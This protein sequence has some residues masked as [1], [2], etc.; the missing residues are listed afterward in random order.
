MRSV[1]RLR[2]A[3]PRALRSRRFT[4][5]TLA[6]PRP[7]C[8]TRGGVPRK[9]LRRH[10]AQRPRP[11]GIGIGITGEELR[12]AEPRGQPEHLATN[13]AEAHRAQIDSS[14]YPCTLEMHR[15]LAQMYVAD[16]R[17]TATYEAMAPGMAQ[18]VHDAI[19]ANAARRAPG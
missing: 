7:L 4:R 8:R 17:F 3:G 5:A 16:P 6:G 10:L 19:E 11:G 15:A 12:K 14:F 18:Y 2:R 9:S 13:A 1:A